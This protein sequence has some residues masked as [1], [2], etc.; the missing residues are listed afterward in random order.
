MQSYLE[1][2]VGR[3]KLAACLHTPPPERLTMAA[4]V[5]VC[6]HGLTGTRIGTSYR[7]VTLAR[8]LAEQNMACLRFDFRG[9]GESDGQFQDLTVRRLTEDLKA[10]VAALDHAP[11]CDP[12][13]IG[14]V[15][16]SFGAFTTSLVSDELSSLGCL[17]FWAPVANVR[18]L[19]DRD[20]TDEAWAFLRE[21]DWV[22]HRGLRMGRAFLEAVPDTDAPEKLA[23][24]PRPLLI[25]H[26]SGDQ[27]VPL[28]HATAYEAAMRK[29]G[30]EV[31]LEVLSVDDHGMRSVSA[32]DR[33]I[34]GSVSWLRCFLHP[35][36]PPLST[37]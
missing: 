8:R 13:R 21:N 9:C 23:L 33:I 7:F 27:H 1:I 18:S 28:D 14:I 37:A 5:V 36:A 26:G 34:E 22:D 19:V 24:Q 2:P 17:V 12:T 16:S 25:F 20:M 6:C 30:V 32:N 31:Q 11:R 3:E 29:S 10:A 4:P 35:E 15:A